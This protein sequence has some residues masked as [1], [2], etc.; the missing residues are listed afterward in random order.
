[1]REL[2]RIHDAAFGCGF[3][4]TDKSQLNVGVKGNITC[5]GFTDIAA[6]QVIDPDPITSII[7]IRQ[8][9][10]WL[11]FSHPAPAGIGTYRLM[12]LNEKNI[13]HVADIVKKLR[14]RQLRR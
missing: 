9:A 3:I 8:E 12:T 10:L 2:L 14:D 5:D 6:L 13:Q 1:M 11:S 4:C 7:Y